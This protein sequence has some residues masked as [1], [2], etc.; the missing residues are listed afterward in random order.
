MTHREDKIIKDFITGKLNNAERK[1]VA[2]ILTQ[3]TENYNNNTSENYEFNTGAA[4]NKFKQKNKIL[5]SDISEKKSKKQYFFKV[6][7]VLTILISLSLSYYFM[8]YAGKHTI[9]VKAKNEIKE[10]TL[11]DGSVLTLNINSE[12]KYPKKFSENE[13]SAKFEGEGFFI[14]KR[15]KQKPFKIKTGNS[16]ITV[17]GTSFNVNT[18]KNKTEVIVASGRV[19]L[20]TKQKKVTLKIGEKGISEKGFLRKTVVKNQNYIAWK[21]HFF[22]YE[23]EKLK[24]IVSDINKVYNVNISFK[25]PKTGE[26]VTG[27]TTFDNYDIQTI[28]KLICETH[29]L[30]AE[31]KGKNIILSY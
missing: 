21:T 7:A 12:I 23:N 22:S 18:K 31:I 28:V 5:N 16:E 1:K 24:N 25:N 26:I 14:I 29:N 9:S 6:A 27:K 10:I 20:K 30:K 17:K 3:S 15:N 13:R 4:W 19:E 8:S 2:E 11:P